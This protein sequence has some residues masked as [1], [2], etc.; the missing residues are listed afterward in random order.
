M[1]TRFLFCWKNIHRCYRR[2]RLRKAV[3]LLWTS[4]LLCVLL[5]VFFE[6]CVLYWL[7]RW[8]GFP[9]AP[10]IHLLLGFSGEST[11]VLWTYPARG[12]GASSTVCAFI[13]GNCWCFVQWTFVDLLSSST[14]YG[15][16]V[17][18]GIFSHCFYR[19]RI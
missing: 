19:L 4:I 2:K 8:P 10:P 3:D 5:G 9:F 7:D 15:I 6:F 14:F 11:I 1:L 18:S 17:H 16:F 12:T 13:T